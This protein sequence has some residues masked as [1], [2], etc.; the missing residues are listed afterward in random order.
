MEEMKQ[1]AAVTVTVYNYLGNPYSGTY[2]GGTSIGGFLPGE[3]PTAA[4]PDKDKH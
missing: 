3:N 1:G 2:T 4:Q